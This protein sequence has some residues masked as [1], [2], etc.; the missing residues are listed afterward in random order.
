MSPKPGF[1]MRVSNAWTLRGFKLETR[2]TGVCA[3]IS[4][5]THIAMKSN[6]EIF[7]RTMKWFLYAHILDNCAFLFSFE[8]SLQM[9]SYFM[10]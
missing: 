6:G 2:D 4:S 9:I 8:F 7:I 5:A 3:A 1:P 10:S